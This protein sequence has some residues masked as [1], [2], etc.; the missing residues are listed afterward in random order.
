MNTD[1]RYTPKNVVYAI[2]LVLGGIDLDPTNN[3]INSTNA[4]NYFTELKS[5]FIHDWN[6]YGIPKTVYMNPPF[7]Y[8]KDFIAKLISEQKRLGFD[9]IA[10]LL[11]GTI[12]NKSTQSY[13]ATAKSICFWHGRLN[14]VYPENQK[15]KKGNDRD[16]IF[17][18][19]GND[20]E[21]EARFDNIFGEYGLILKPSK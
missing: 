19:W 13:L 15:Q 11:S 1:E 14:F 16:I 2:H 18:Y 7:S 9:A 20:N 3:Y 17:V 6:E 21:V 12:H 4:I 8:S 5:C 10:C